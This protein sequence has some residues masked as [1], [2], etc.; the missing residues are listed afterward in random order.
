MVC[1]NAEVDSSIDGLVPTW[2]SYYLKFYPA[3]STTLTS[4]SVLTYVK[5][6]GWENDVTLCPSFDACTKNCRKEYSVEKTTTELTLTSTFLDTTDCVCDKPVF[7]I[8]SDTVW[9]TA[10]TNFGTV[11]DTVQLWQYSAG[12]LDITVWQDDVSPV[13]VDCVWEYSIGISSSPA[14]TLTGL[15]G[16]IFASMVAFVLV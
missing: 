14:T 2:C 15:L 8:S 4:S 16:L 11:A 5:Q 9:E 1:S 10:S 6:G 13:T 3:A 7:T 12:A